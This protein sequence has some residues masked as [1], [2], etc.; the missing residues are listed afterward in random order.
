MKKI[1]RQYKSNSY[2]K[3][4]DNWEILKRYNERK[5]QEKENKFYIEQGP[6][7]FMPKKVFK[8]LGKEVAKEILKDLKNQGS[9]KRQAQDR[10]F[11]KHLKVFDRKK[12]Q[13]R[14]LLKK[15]KLFK[16]EYTLFPFAKQI[17]YSHSNKN[18]KTAENII[19]YKINRLKELNKSSK[20]ILKQK[21]PKGNK[22]NFKSISQR[23]QSTFNKI[24]K[25]SNFRKT[26]GHNFTNLKNKNSLFC[27]KKSKFSFFESNKKN[28]K[29]RHQSSRMKSNFFKTQVNRK[30]KFQSIVS[31]ENIIPIKYR[32]KFQK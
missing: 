12:V 9:S 16:P 7:S 22:S 4:K 23:S 30:D 13:L 19:S 26:V 10:I 5:I 21:E 18:I 1:K 28:Q 3:K 8:V 2:N 11:K 25:N 32:N 31:I 17:I 6:K 24:R 20:Q 29:I 14:K 27:R 15:Q